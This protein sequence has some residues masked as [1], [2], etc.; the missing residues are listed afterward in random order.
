[1]TSAPTTR[2]FEFDTV[3]DGEGGVF[4]PQRKSTYSAAE[5]EAARAEA[6]AEGEQ[7]MT[8]TLQAQ[9]AQSLAQIAA[10]LG[11]MMPALA[12]SIHEHREGSA[13]LAMAAAGKIADAALERFPEAPARAALDALAREIEAAPKLVISLPAETAE[14]TG[15][16]L[17]QAAETASYSGQI[18]VRADP[19]LP[20]AAFVFDWGDGKAAYDPQAAMARVTAALEAALAAEGLHAEPL[21]PELGSSD[22]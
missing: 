21:P 14:S 5:L 17:R 9:V 13:Q 7:R 6:V 20:T 1:M 10:A 4:Q 2:R 15:E 12:H 18:T 3:F 22:V 16:L 8:A 11:Q 19:S